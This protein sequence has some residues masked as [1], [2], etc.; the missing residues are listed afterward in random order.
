MCAMFT[1]TSVSAQAAAPTVRQLGGAGTY[2][3]TSS[4]IN[5]ARGAT[6][7]LNTSVAPI[8]SATKNTN[9][10]SNNTV[11][12]ATNRL[13]VG[14]YLGG[15]KSVVGGASIKNQTVTNAI[16]SSGGSNVSVDVNQINQDI[17]EIN[18][19]ISQLYT[20]IDNVTN[21]VE[22]KQDSLASRDGYIIIENGEIYVDVD[23]LK[24]QMGT[25]GGTGTDGRE[26]VLGSTDT[27]LV[28]K[29]SDE[30][31]SAYRILISKN[32]IR[33]A[34]GERGEKG[35]AGKI[36]VDAMNAAI[37]TAIA[38]TVYTKSDVDAALA[39]KAD[40]TDLDAKANTADVYTK[41]DVDTALATKAD[42]SDVAE[43]IA[44][45]VKDKANAADVYTREQ[46]DNM[47][48][49]VDLT[50]VNE[51]L[52][53]K[54]PIPGEKCIADSG[55]CVLSVNKNGDYAWVNVTAP[56]E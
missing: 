28:W 30:S 29:Y 31:D 1:M 12:T 42:S 32:D 44:T 24:G 55:L 45:A 46:I 47:D 10:N 14:K 33:G 2:N 26:I 4:A 23:A 43:K 20:N 17:N 39:T 53:K 49:N 48:F 21:K 3:G 18:K 41:S 56:A 7:R 50:Q 13:S 15:G 22:S 25:T 34:R 40:K 6:M 51:E 38:D 54:I 9:N 36:D 37:T 11:Q 5:A 8:S 16:N 27:D 52:A 19:N 35:D